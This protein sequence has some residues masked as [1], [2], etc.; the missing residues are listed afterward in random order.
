MTGAI[1]S[2]NLRDSTI[3]E[4]N[5]GIQ[6]V[7]PTGSVFFKQNNIL[8]NVKFN[9]LVVGVGNRS[10][11]ASSSWWGTTD[12]AIIA[13]KIH[14]QQDDVVLSAVVFEPIALQR[15]ASAP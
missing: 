14:D 3:R 9:L 1:N 4:N 12:K 6:V 2:V 7:G 15:I 13:G 10:V 5:V 11:D 8:D